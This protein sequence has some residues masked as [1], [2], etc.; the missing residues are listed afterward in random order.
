M[1]IKT[2]QKMDYSEEIALLVKTPSLLP[3]SHHLITLNPFVCANGFLRV[4]GRLQNANIIYDTKCPMLLE[5]A[6]PLTKLIIRKTHI[7]TLHGGAK[8]TLASL[9]NRFWVPN[10]R[11]AIRRCIYQ[12]IV[13]HKLSSATRR[14]IMASLPHP[15]VNHSKVFSHS[16]VDFA[17]PFNMRMSKHRGRGTTKAYVCIF[18][19][20]ATKALHVELVSDLTAVGFIAAFKRFVARRGVCTDIYSYCGTNFV[21]A[22]KILNEQLR[23]LNDENHNEIGNS[24]QFKALNGISTPPDHLTLVVCGRPG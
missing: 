21:G 5:K 23:Q 17:G 2:A 1:W 15:R 6:N 12:C 24:R 13:C 9:R 18:V 7:D 20:F 14:Q 8:I 3:S 4:G 22:N 11:T 10:A 16:G 19:C